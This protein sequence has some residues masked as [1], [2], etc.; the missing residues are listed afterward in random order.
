M[1][2]SSH[3]LGQEMNITASQ[4]RQDLSCFGEFGQRRFPGFDDIASDLISI[5]DDG[6]ELGKPTGDRRFPTAHATG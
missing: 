3:Q 4:I 6:T 1:R 2:I 5:D